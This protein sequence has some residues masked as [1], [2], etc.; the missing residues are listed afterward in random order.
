[1]KRAAILWLAFAAAGGAELVRDGRTRHTIVISATAPPAERRAA[2]ELRRFVREMS[3]AELTVRDDSKAVRGPMVLIGRS[4]ALERV[5]P[6]LRLEAMGAE[7]F[8]IE[9]RGRHLV[10]AGGG[11]RGTMYGVYEFLERLGCRWF[12]ADV[13]RVPRLKTISID[14]LRVRQ[15]PAF[16]YREPFFREAFQRD[17][18]ARN[19]VNGNHADLDASTGGKVGYY[20]FVHSFYQLVPPEKYFAAHPEYFSLVD[21]KRRAEGGQLCLTHEAVLRIATETVERWIAEHPEAKIFSVSQ[22][23]WEGWCECD[24]CRRVEEEE[25]GVH[26]GPVLRF[27]NALAERIGKKHPDKLIDT[28]AYW[29]TEAPPLR[30][31]P[32][33]NVRVRLCPIGIC[34]AHSFAQCPRSAYFYR[35]L[36][37]WA[38]ITDQLYIWHYNT[39]FTHYLLPFPD[40]DELGADIPLYRKTGVKGL[41]LQGAYAEGGGGEMAWLKSW[42]LAKLLWDPSRDLWKLADE[43]LEGV[44]GRAAPWMRK[45]LALLHAEVRPAPAG[46]GQHLWIFNVPD[47]SDGLLREGFRLFDE[48]EKAAETEGIRKRVRKDRLSLEYLA[49]LRASQYEVRGARYAPADLAGLQRQAREFLEQAKQHGIRSLHEGR[50]LEFDER[51]YAELREYAVESLENRVWAAAAA[52]ELNGRVVRF[53]HK[54]TGREMLRRASLSD[55]RHPDTGGIFATVH[56]HRRAP[57]WRAQWRAERAGEG[58]L[59]LSAVLENG[60][61]ARHRIGLSERGLT[62]ETILHNP[63]GE[64][65]AAAIQHRAEAAPGD[66]DAE[67]IEYTSAGG[68]PEKRRLIEPEQEPAGRLVLDFSAPAETGWLLERAQFFASS[69]GAARTGAQWT[70]KTPAGVTLIHW[71]E[72]VVLKPGGAL[73]LRSFYSRK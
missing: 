63:T 43:F 25:G 27:V 22:N 39:N 30:A 37:A 53:F 19:R 67:V 56:P 47:Y 7:E 23:D 14:G 66:M 16:E 64:D 62:M 59:L 52:P 12:T 68:N 33:P 15:A 13:T 38:K 35:N 4:R 32:A 24:R 41:F 57:A 48:A 28:L 9:A 31:R 1:M 51:R 50:P 5:A 2:E 72:E 26:S 3:G 69:D 58:Q 20:P 42:V 11:E 61:Q 29:Y 45:Y 34:T 49:L 40:L 46:R 21:G 8:V 18:A 70:A 36:Q 54:I 17:W 6:D 65:L 55:L 73:R 10:I 60:L 44:Y 71:T